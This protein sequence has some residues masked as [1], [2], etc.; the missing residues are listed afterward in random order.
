MKLLFPTKRDLMIE[1]INVINQPAGKR[2]IVQYTDL[3]GRLYVRW[4]DGS[5]GVIRERG[6]VYKEIIISKK[7][8]RKIKKLYL[9]LL[10]KSKRIKLWLQNLLKLGSTQ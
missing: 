1:T 10:L 5:K 8:I 9:I 2:G 7:N 3:D 6:D 4:L